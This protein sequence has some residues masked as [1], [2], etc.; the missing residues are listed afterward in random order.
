MH[1]DDNESGQ[2][3]AFVRLGTDFTDNYYEIEIPKLIATPS[4]Q[5]ARRRCLARPKMSWTWRLRNSSN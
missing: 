1:N 5:P 3:S 4:R 2:V